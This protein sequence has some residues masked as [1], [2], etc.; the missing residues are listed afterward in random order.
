MRSLNK[1]NFVHAPLPFIHRSH[2]QTCIKP[3]QEK[4]KNAANVKTSH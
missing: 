3:E 4:N 2:E 1:L